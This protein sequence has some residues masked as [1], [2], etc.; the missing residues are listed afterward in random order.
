MTDA[1]A[2]AAPAAIPINGPAEGPPDAADDAPDAPDASPGGLADWGHRRR[3]P[4]ELRSRPF[5]RWPEDVSLLTGLT[6]VTLKRLRAEND[7]PRLAAFGR[8]LGTTLPWLEEWVAGHELP[9]GARL[10]AP[11][12]ASVRP[13]QRI[14][15]TGRAGTKG[16]P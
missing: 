3:L 15:G 12:S 10:R 8:Q 4:S 1:Q 13:G 14:G 7:A 5:L 2:A 11:T 16:Q 9:S 6:I